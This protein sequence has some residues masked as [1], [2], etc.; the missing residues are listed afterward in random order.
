MTRR[1]PSASDIV[2]MLEPRGTR[3]GNIVD[4]LRRVLVS[5]RVRPGTPLPLD[6]IAERFGV[7]LT[8]LREALRTLQA[9][10]LIQH[11]HGRGYRVSIATPAEL[12]EL[13]AVRRALEGAA[14]ASATQRADAADKQAIAASLDRQRA[15]V[16]AGDIATWDLESR[17]FH[18]LLVGPSGMPTLCHLIQTA[19]NTIGVAQPMSRLPHHQVEALLADHEEM[20]RLFCAGDQ[21]DQLQRFA[22]EHLDQVT[23]WLHQAA[24]SQGAPPGAPPAWPPR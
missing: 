9:E 23:A 20:A 22:A 11:V 3:Q 2:A 15:A 24:K 6:E 13:Y 21:A 19:A 5:G 1:V 17:T 7:S 10:G 14:L 4:E 18:D 8:P 16:A 12:A